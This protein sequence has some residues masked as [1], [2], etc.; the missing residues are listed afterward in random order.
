MNRSVAVSIVILLLSAESVHAAD[1][2][3]ATMIV[4]DDMAEIDG[5]LMNVRENDAIT[6]ENDVK[7]AEVSPQEQQSFEQALEAIR[8]QGRTDE[9]RDTFT[10]DSDFS[11]LSDHD[12]LFEGRFDEDEQVDFDLEPETPG[13]L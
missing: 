4:I 12:F 5:I 6:R 2:L 9:D 7:S 10:E 1:D 3:E 11:Q 13:A 8:R